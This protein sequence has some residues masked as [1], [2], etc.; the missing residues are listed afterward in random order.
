MEL[1]AEALGQVDLR[2]HVF[3]GWVFGSVRGAG[4]RQLS[5]Y[6][7]LAGTKSLVMQSGDVTLT[8]AEC[9]VKRGLVN[10][11]RDRRVSVSEA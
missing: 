6:M 10:E 4:K 3:G 5:W 11:N 1:W 7:S 8:G 2:S 9:Y